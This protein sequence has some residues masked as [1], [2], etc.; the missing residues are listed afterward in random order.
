MRI[1]SAQ[2]GGEIELDCYSREY[3]E[4]HLK[5]CVSVIEQ[6]IEK[7][8]A[9]EAILAGD[10]KEMYDH[11]HDD[12]P[13]IYTELSNAMT[14]HK[15]I[16]MA[17]NK[18]RKALQ[19]PYFG[20]IDYLDHED[21]KKSSLYLGKHGVMKSAT[22]IEVVDWRAPISSIYYES[23]VGECNYRVPEGELR[24]ITLNLKRTYEVEKDKLLDFY[25]SEVV[26]N[27]ELL[28]KYLA[29]NKEAVLGEIIATIQKEQNDII[30]QSPF[31][32]VVVQG[33]AGSG[34]TTVAMHRISYILYNYQEKFQPKEFFVIGSNRILLD[35][36]TS[37][38]P[39]LDV[40]GINQMTLEQ[41]FL[42][43]LEEEIMEEKY[44]IISHNQRKNKEF[45][46][47][48]ERKGS[49]SYLSE[50]EMYLCRKEKEIIPRKT[51]VYE[52]AVLFSEEAF[53]DFMKN[54]QR[55][56]AHAKITMLNERALNKIK[57]YFTGR[58]YE[59][60]KEERKAAIKQY[61]N[62]YGPKKWKY[63][64]ITLYQEF[65]QWMLLRTEGEEQLGI[66]DCILALSKKEVDVYDLAA[67]LYIK[68]RMV[69]TEELED[70][71]HVVV[72]EA[73]DYGAMVFGVLRYVLPRCTFTVMGDVSQNIN[74]D[75]GMNDWE[76]L[77]QKVFNKDRDTFGVLAKS[78]RNTIEISNYAAS[79]LAH[80]SFPTY[81]VE[82][83]IRH[84]VMVAKHQVLEESEM[85]SS[86]VT[87]IKSW[88][89]NGYDTIA[90]ICKDSES[91]GKVSK[92]LSKELAVMEG[93]L[94][95]AVFSKGIMVLPI[96]LT[97]GLEF[98]TV[99]LWNPNKENYE[100]NDA[101]AKLLYVAA[102][103]AL[104][105]LT[106]VYRNKLSELL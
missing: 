105:E 15:S 52:E 71:K 25:D 103:R 7:Y 97:K 35:Y 8:A 51:V 28:T 77:K 30:R 20:R 48:A 34:K 44:K 12:S 81:Q 46:K 78:Y 106:M 104:H 82:P 37:V 84:G 98:D 13:E 63:S 73:Q 6:N 36:I 24:E 33:V 101:N 88:Q 95:N 49:L 92:L 94:E 68:R 38:L 41:F 56:S 100:K 17:L 93:S 21:D 76:V 43:L 59:Y 89:A 5:E 45:K 58:D 3:E 102:T 74:Y 10:I 99:L 87:M 83:I 54:N 26:A 18:N 42:F 66:K 16:K 62:Y 65:L 11:Y 72:D 90:I 67:L 80:C 50:L 29:K 4:Q 22:E 70:A 32:N 1:N 61:N 19:K 40:Y 75:S 85:V 69:L 14:M 9:Q 47:F 31:H 86:A 23:E 39:D 27:D 79:I 96:Q 53:D 2:N 55:W 64:I 60:E 57:N 91:S